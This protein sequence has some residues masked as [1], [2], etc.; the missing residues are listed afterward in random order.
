MIAANSNTFSTFFVADLES[1]VKRRVQQ[2]TIIPE[3][4]GLWEKS[5]LCSDVLEGAWYELYDNLQAG[6]NKIKMLIRESIDNLQ[7]TLVTESK[8]CITLAVLGPLGVGKSFFLNTLLNLGLKDEVKMKDGPLP[9]APEDSQTPLPIYVKFA[10]N[11]QVLFYKQ[12]ADPNPVEWFPEEKMAKDSLA[13]VNS[14]ILKRFQDKESLDSTGYVVLQG[15]FRVF[16]EMKTRAMTK[17]ELHLELEVD[18]EFVDVPG[19]GDDTGN[20]AISG[21]LS[22]ADVIHFFGSGQ[23]GRPVSAE[24]I[25]QVFRRRDGE[26][27]FVSRPKIVHIFNDRNPCPPPLNEFDD[28]CKEKKKRLDKAWSSFISS[29]REKDGSLYQEA[30]ETLPKLNSEDFLDKLSKE[31]ECIYFHAESTDFLSSLKSVVHNHVRDVKIKQTIHPF[32]QRV[33]WAAKILRKRVD[34]TTKKGNIVGIDEGQVFFEMLSRV[35]E[36]EES[37]LIMSFMNK[38]LPLESDIKSLHEFL[39]SKFLLSLKTRQF[40]AKV[41]KRSLESYASRLKN[42]AFHNSNLG[43][44]EDAPKDILELT[45]IACIARVEHFCENVA[46]TYLLGFLKKRK[47]QIS[48]QKDDTLD[49]KPDA[50]VESKSDLVER[51]LH[52]LLKKAAKS[53][54]DDRVRKPKQASRPPYFQLMKTLEELVVKLVPASSFEDACKTVFLNSLKD[55]L[56]KVIE[57][58][59]D[60]IRKINPHPKLDVR[61]LPSLPEKMTIAKDKDKEIPSQSSPDKIISEVTRLLL[62]PDQKKKKKKKDIIREMETKLKL[63]LGYLKGQQPQNADQRLWTLGLVHVLSDKEHFD[64]PL[65][66]EITL[67]PTAHEALLNVAREILFAHQKSSI[68]CN[69]VKTGDEQLHPDHEDVIHLKVDAPQKCLEALVSS[70]MQNTLNAMCAQFKDPSRHVAPIFIPIT[71]PGPDIQGNYFLDEDPW[72]NSSPLHEESGEKD[73]EARGDSTQGNALKLN[74]FLVVEPNH[75][76]RLKSTIKDLRYPREHDVQLIYVVLPQKGRGIGVTRSVIKSLAECLKFSLYWTIDDNVQ[77]MY[78]YVQDDHRWLKCPLTSGLLFGQRVFQGCLENSV[79]RPS[80]DEIEGIFKSIEVWEDWAKHGKPGSMARKILYS[81]KSLSEVQR[82]RGLL[83]LPFADISEI[84]KGD[85][86][87]EAKLKAYERE[88][89]STCKKVLFE[90]TINQISGV[91]LADVK[92]KGSDFMSR[93]PKADYMR[94]K[95]LSQVVLNNGDALKGKNF[96]SDE[97]I[98]HDEELQIYDENKC[99][100]PYWGIKGS[101]TSFRR[102]LEI[103]GLVGY[104]VI[105]I[106]YKCKKLRNAFD[107]ESSERKAQRLGRS[108]DVDV[109]EDVDM[110]D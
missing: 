28:L 96:V 34:T 54:E 39:Y 44:P 90:D 5:S 94:S 30:R 101:E 38:A 75:L 7:S 102:A 56:P 9:S 74:I 65:P 60:T 79:K 69:I 41:L 49:W 88:F 91:S 53:L 63:K 25:A 21:A 50:C 83:H 85:P 14:T 97:V 1:Y 87:K 22:K 92:S 98:L 100:D 15:P 46:P 12:E 70:S 37:E 24:D 71:R 77:T 20:K 32:L 6:T 16:T 17:E 11:V 35:Y 109:N 66:P 10:S 106:V 103:S 95:T 47:K 43:S 4:L 36:D 93:Y 89:V 78:R 72:L 107:V 3:K 58:C 26:F 104:R 19:L 33:H 76:E 59:N 29:L 110:G 31:S 86:D 18:V 105:R 57:F 61:A 8:V 48:L 40:L 82:N 55:K 84:C 67:D 64:I 42:K 2:F 81:E 13:R 27:E 68:F 45:E 80:D 99:N 62:N 73:G 52:L 23:S 51:Y 108:K